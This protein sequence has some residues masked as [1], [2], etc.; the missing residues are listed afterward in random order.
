MKGSKLVAQA[1][2]MAEITKSLIYLL[3]NYKHS[4]EFPGSVHL[5]Q[6]LS[7]IKFNLLPTN[8]LHDIVVVNQSDSEKIG[9]P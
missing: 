2:R 4:L 9:L 5:G 6:L 8:F 3:D 7:I 1:L